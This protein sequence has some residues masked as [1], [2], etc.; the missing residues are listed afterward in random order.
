ML[1]SLGL[2]RFQNLEEEMYFCFPSLVQECDRKGDS[3][4]NKYKLL[5]AKLR[6][7]SSFMVVMIAFLSHF[8][9]EVLQKSLNCSFKKGVKYLYFSSLILLV[10][11]G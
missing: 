3:D 6:V 2:S 5:Y 11:N 10:I 1:V 9:L 4:R 8:L 7:S